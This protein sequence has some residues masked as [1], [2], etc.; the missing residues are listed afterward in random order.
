M[1]KTEKMPMWR[2]VLIA[3]CSLLIIACLILVGNIK[4][5]ITNEESERNTLTAVF[6]ADKILSPFLNLSE[7]EYEEFI[8]I[9][10][11]LISKHGYDPKY[12]H[13]LYNNKRFIDIFGR[14]AFNSTIEEYGD[15]SYEYRCEML[16]NK[17]VSDAFKYL[18][19]PFNNDGS[20]DNSKGLGENWEKYNQM[21]ISAKEK[22]IRADFQERYEKNVEKEEKQ[23]K[24]WECILISIILVSGLCIFCII[25][26]K[27]GKKNLHAR[28]LALYTIICF[29]ID[30]F[31]CVV[32]TIDGHDL[33]D[34]L[35]VIIFEFLLSVV[36]LSL[37]EAFL[38]RKSHQDYYSNYLIPEWLS[39]NLNITNEYRKRL[40]I[41]FLIYPFFF[42]VPLPLVGNL[43]FAFYVLPVLLILGIIRVVMWIKEGKRID[44][45]P[46][47]HND[48][49]RLY[50][51]H[52]GKLIDAD[53]DFCRYCGKKL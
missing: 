45:K 36:V 21:S 9:N 24:L 43:F 40:L 4:S 3:I 12:I 41:F 1:D 26:R 32:M 13:G 44:T 11:A 42:I 22:F 5:I 53:S 2:R 33:E 51:R 48:R 28:N 37:T 25:S 49:A 16:H 52:C 7:H 15:N 29:V 27:T 20:R 14:D 18:Y 38:A 6:E 46:K 19:C 34:I 23:R 8:K 35:V 10:K 31:I 39:S 17:D 50:C 30:F 47:I